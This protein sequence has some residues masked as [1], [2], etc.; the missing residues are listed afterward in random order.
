[1]KRILND[2]RVKSF[3]EIAGVFLPLGFAFYNGVL[4][5]LHHTEFNI[6]IFVYYA[7]LFL[8]K[9]ML[10]LSNHIVGM[11]DQKKRKKI[12]CFSFVFLLLLDLVLIGPFFF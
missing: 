8:I 1:M 10:T 5:Y 7:L 4:G 3:L 9:C 6:Y 2:P 12:S 11:D